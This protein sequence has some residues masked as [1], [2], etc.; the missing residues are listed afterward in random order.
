MFHLDRILK[1]V[2]LIYVCCTPDFNLFATSIRA[3]LDQ[4]Q[5]AIGDSVTLSIEVEGDLDES[6]DLPEVDGIVF[7]G[8]G[9]SSSISII[10]SLLTRA[11]CP[12]G[13]SA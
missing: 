4:T 10:N 12:N 1:S 6:I 3:S 13:V 9:T 2:M 5:V 8:S 11:C 7:S